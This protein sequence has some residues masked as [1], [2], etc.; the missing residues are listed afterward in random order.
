[1]EFRPVIASRPGAGAARPGCRAGLVAVA[2]AVLLGACGQLEPGG[3]TSAA[4]PAPQRTDPVIAFIASAS[5]GAEDRIV[6]PGGQVARVRLIRAYAAASGRECREATIG[7][8][9]GD[10]ARLFCR[11]G[12][13]WT[14]ARPLLRGGGIPR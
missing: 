1:M 8:G 13:T 11:D 3:V 9:F 2:L 6:L 5:P 10:T 7:S 14:E 4:L 12:E